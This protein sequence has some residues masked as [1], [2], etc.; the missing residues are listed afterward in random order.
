MKT[1]D[2]VS[3]FEINKAVAEILYPCADEIPEQKDAWVSNG[4]ECQVVV[5]V[6]AEGFKRDYCNSWADMGPIICDRN[7][8]LTF[9]HI[10]NRAFANHNDHGC[11]HHDNPIRAAATV[12]LM[13]NNVEPEDI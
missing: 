10:S 1:W 2:D 11:Q 4:T 6:G 3:D 12:Y 8:N 7:I 9:S 13:M 5:K